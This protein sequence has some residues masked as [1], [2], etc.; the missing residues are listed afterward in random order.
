MRI[1]IIAPEFPPQLGGMQTYAMEV[2]LELSRRGH[3]V[4][5]FT[6]EIHA[7]HDYH[8]PFQVKPVLR[9]RHW[10]D[11]PALQKDLAR[12]DVVHVMNACYAWL[13]LQH[14]RVVVSIHGNDFLR[15]AAVAAPDL[16]TRLK[17]PF[18]SRLDLWI[19]RQ[20]TPRLLRRGMDR[21]RHVFANSQYTEQLFLT[22]FPQCQG[23]TSTTYVGVSE[24]FFDDAPESILADRK[25]EVVRLVTVSR[26]DERRKNVDVVIR[27][28][29]ILKEECQFHYTIVGSGSLQPGLMNLVNEQGLSD[30][31]SFAGAVSGDELRRILSRS[32]LF[33]LTSSADEK[34][35]EGF[36]ICYLESNA[37][38]VPVLAARC[39]GAIEAVDEGV[40]GMFVDT[41]TIES[42]AGAL[43]EFISGKRRFA[44][45]AC[46]SH[47]SKFRW[48]NV[49][50]RFC[51]VYERLLSDSTAGNKRRPELRAT[52]SESLESTSHATV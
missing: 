42:V 37:L 20:R 35:Y 46:R 31:V 13:S 47:A 9:Y 22:R 17:L 32:D 51:E 16:R 45:A 52:G 48:A 10:F 39:G 24:D 21:V 7:N 28:L 12:Y 50:D 2:A 41:A 19:G 25:S 36:G 1:A 23:R 8:V 26:L 6:R 30:R 5:V 49:V 3:D 44:A 38:G 18:G 34:S 43:R 15:P 14:D 4:T 27:A 11:R 29:A 33:V 40:S